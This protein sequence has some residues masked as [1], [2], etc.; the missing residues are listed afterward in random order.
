MQVVD[1]S[2]NELSSVTGIEFK[3]VLGLNTSLLDLD[4][5]WNKIFSDGKHYTK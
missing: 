1:L 2:Y 5:K 3:K 4:L